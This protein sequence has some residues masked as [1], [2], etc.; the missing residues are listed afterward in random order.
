MKSLILYDKKENKQ[1]AVKKILNHK[2]SNKFLV[3]SGYQINKNT[4]NV[5][6]NDTWKND[7]MQIMF[8]SIFVIATIITSP[9]V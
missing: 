1:A 6:W 3:D 5:S 7:T 8:F 9:S 2:L 4:K